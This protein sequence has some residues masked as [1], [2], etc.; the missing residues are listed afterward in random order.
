MRIS[1]ARE[2]DPA[3]PRVAAT[4]ETVKKMKALGVDVASSPAPASSPAFSTRTIRRLA[5]R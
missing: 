1:V 4:P 5:P 3:E 2:R